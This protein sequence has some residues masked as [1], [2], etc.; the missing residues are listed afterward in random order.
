MITSF[1]RARQ[2][3]GTLIEYY[4]LAVEIACCRPSTPLR[5]GVRR[6]RVALGLKA[7][8]G[9]AILVGVGL[10]KTELRFVERAELKLLPHGAFAP[11][12]AV[13]GL[14]P[15]VARKHLERSIAAAHRL[16][17]E[18]IRDA[19][20]RITHAGHEVREC[21]VLVGSGMPNWTTDEILAAHTRMHTAEG[22]LFRN[23]LVAGV[24]AMK[25]EMITLPHKSPFDAAAT[26]LG[27]ARAR[28][29]ALIAALGRQAGPPWGRHQ[30]EAAVAAMVA[31][32]GAAA[33][34]AR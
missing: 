3:A 32:G 17:E 20:E 25:L 18:A 5:R 28:L 2:A 12:H 15:E 8:T 24:A 16:A 14:E 13:E 11:Y 6:M 10:N 29:D 9:R 34:L 31:L 33:D 1:A 23:V 19:V 22:E 4:R 7:R 27:I 26:A 30:K 21:G